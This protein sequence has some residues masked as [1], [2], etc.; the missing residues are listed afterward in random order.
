M[1][2]S[3]IVQNKLHKIYFFMGDKS[4]VVLHLMSALL[5]VQTGSSANSQSFFITDVKIHHISSF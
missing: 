1:C 4:S 3:F 5:K 2:T